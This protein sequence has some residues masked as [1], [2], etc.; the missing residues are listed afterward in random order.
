MEFWHPERG[1]FE[2]PHSQLPVDLTQIVQGSHLVV[3]TLPLALQGSCRLQQLDSKL[4]DRTAGLQA[5]IWRAAAASTCRQVSTRPQC[6]PPP[7]FRSLQFRRP[8]RAPSISRICR[9][10]RCLR[11]AR[12]RCRR[13]CRAPRPAWRRSDCR[14]PP[15][16]FS[17]TSSPSSLNS[18]NNRPLTIL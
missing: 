12:E 5:N 18:N 7:K 1:Y 15:A 13:C 6:L 9:T 11:T 17:P 10:F 4:T 16:S 2:I 14:A 3:E 8:S